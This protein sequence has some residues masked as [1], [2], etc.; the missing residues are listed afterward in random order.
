MTGPK[1]PIPPVGEDFEKALLEG[2][3]FVA[4]LLKVGAV[5]DTGNTKILLG[6]RER[7]EEL[8]GLRDRTSGANAAR[9]AR[10]GTRR[11]EARA[12]RDEGLTIAQIALKLGVHPRTVERYLADSKPPAPRRHTRPDVERP[13]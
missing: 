1:P 7:R 5:I 13:G 9:A 4:K 3:P 11:D 10:A 12:W 6:P 8:R 2:D